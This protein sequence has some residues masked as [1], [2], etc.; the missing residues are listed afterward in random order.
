MSL[1]TI[2]FPSKIIA[3]LYKDSLIESGITTLLSDKKK[4]QPEWKFLGE[5]KKK[6]LIIVNFPDAV[7]IPDKQLGF[8]TNLLS[9]CKLNLGDVAVLNFQN[10]SEKDLK[11]ILSYFNAKIIFLFGVSPDELGMPLIF[12][13]FQIQIFNETT[14]LYSPALSEIEPDKVLKSKLWVCFK[15]IFTL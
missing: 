6:V 3:D 14:Y 5:N 13:H 15:K 2:V 8:L 10:Y 12:P 11:E 7:Y 1:N 9:A 4:L